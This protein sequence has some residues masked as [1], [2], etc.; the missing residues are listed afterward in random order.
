MVAKCYAALRFC[1]TDHVW[2]TIFVGVMPLCVNDVLGM[3]IDIFR[4][5][6]QNSVKFVCG[7]TFLSYGWRL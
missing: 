1:N 2:L 4:C 6:E 7:F 3:P 5:C